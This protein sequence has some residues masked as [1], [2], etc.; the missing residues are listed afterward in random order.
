MIPIVDSSPLLGRI[1]SVVTVTGAFREEGR[2]PVMGK[3][4]AC[5][6]IASSFLLFSLPLS[7]S[8]KVVRVGVYENNPK[9]FAGPEAQGRGIFA[10]IIEEVA[11]LEG[12]DL[13]YVPGSWQEGLQR[14]QNGKIDLMP[15]VS[16]LEERDRIFDYNTVP[17]LSDWFQVYRNR[18][19]EVASLLDLDGKRVGVLA[20][21]IQENVFTGMMTDFGFATESRPYEE[22]EEM[23]RALA[24]GTV[25]AAITNRFYGAA[26]AGKFGVEETGV[27]FHPNSLFFA[28]AEGKNAD[29]LGLLDN[30]LETM[31]RDRESA[32]YR[33]LDR[34]LG[35]KPQLHLPVYL[36]WTLAALAAGLLLFVAV[37][38]I[39]KNQVDA[40]TAELREKAEALEEAL[41]DL[42]KAQD[43]AIERE[44][45]H[46]LGQMAS[47]IAHDFNNIL[48]PIIGYSE[49]LVMWPEK[50]KDREDVLKRLKIMH[51]AAHDGT[52]IVDRMR[53]FYKAREGSEE[54]GPV[55]VNAILQEVVALAS[56]RWEKQSQAS[57]VRI[58]V[59]TVLAKIPRVLADPTELREMFMNLLFNAVDAMPEGGKVSLKTTGA[60]GAVRVVVSDTGTGMTE[61]VRRNCL[62]P[63]F[64]TKGDKGTGIGL[65]MVNSTVAKFSGSIKVDSAPGEGTSFVIS[66]PAGEEGVSEKIEETAVTPLQSLTILAVDDDTRSLES[67][68]ELLRTDGHIVVSVSTPGEV[69]E[70]LSKGAFDVVVTDHAM[71]EMSG[72]ELARNVRQTDPGMPVIMIS[73]FSDD[74]ETE[75]NSLEGIS[76]VLRKPA[77]LAEL[78]K[79]F[80]DLGFS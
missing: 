17:A 69:V 29:I 49:V 3:G 14:L 15:D 61:E 35:E 56:P 26:N 9:I 2:V 70:H 64:S 44:R 31:K 75:E 54:L 8:A 60:D 62:Q 39:L 6:V 20:G 79:S 12:W 73:S 19:A 23:F 37:S 57:N 52:R 10:D 27:V 55:D 30:R 63:F 48:T 22:Y 32:Y 53:E 5:G 76:V 74:M 7:S 21:S 13:Q 45:L 68:T 46:A 34:W 72:V 58:T 50:L 16:F 18:D 51:R 36:I 42:E 41:A 33:S 66:F 47:G 4:M 38:T 11:R 67:L 28:A 65:A 25:D 77:S 80:V 59:E 1:V 43:E 71:P 78:R 40:R 24:K